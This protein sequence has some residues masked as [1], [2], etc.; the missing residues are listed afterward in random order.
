MPHGPTQKNYSTKYYK[1]L[2]CDT[3]RERCETGG[4]DSTITHYALCWYLAE[5]PPDGYTW[6]VSQTGGYFKIGSVKNPSTLHMMDCGFSY[7]ND[8]Y[9]FFW[10]GDEMRGMNTLFV[11]GNARVLHWNEAGH[12]PDSALA[13][14]KSGTRC[15]YT[16][17]LSYNYPCNGNTSK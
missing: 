5:T 8:H 4:L 6:Q 13:G 10:H 14:M 11:G 9:Y 3:A 7:T 17:M 12:Y 1:G 15:Y 16:Y 2:W